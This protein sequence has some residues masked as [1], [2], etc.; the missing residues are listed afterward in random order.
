MLE[1]M[2]DVRLPSCINGGTLGCMG[3]MVPAVAPQVSD[4]DRSTTPAG[5]VLEKLA[6]RTEPG[7]QGNVPLL[8]MSPARREERDGG[9]PT[10][11]AGAAAAASSSGRHPAVVMLHGTGGNKEEM[12]PLMQ[13]Y[14]S[15]GYL[16][17]AIDSRWGRVW[18]GPAAGASGALGSA[19]HHDASHAAALTGLQVP[20]GQGGA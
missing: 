9:D 15:C 7:A 20:R 17:A 14:S 12:L 2:V 1:S 18:G 19:M 6:Y 8:V 3:S 11:A 16:T 5:L 13:S 10:T 4:I